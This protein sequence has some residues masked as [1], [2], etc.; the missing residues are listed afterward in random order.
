MRT[1]ALL[2]LAALVAPATLAAAHHNENHGNN[3]TVPSMPS[4][5]LFGLCTAWAHNENGREHGN[6]GNAGPFRWLQQQAEAE[7]QTVEEYCAENARHP[8]LS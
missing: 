3:G 1:L 4:Q 6:A 8:G 7:D 2:L 5:A